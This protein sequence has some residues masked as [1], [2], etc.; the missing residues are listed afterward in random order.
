MDFNDMAGFNLT[1][2]FIDFIGGIKPVKTNAG[3]DNIEVSPRQ[4]DDPAAVGRVFHGKSD[5][6]P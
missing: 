5:A 3:A 2:C 6:R 1:L 4:V